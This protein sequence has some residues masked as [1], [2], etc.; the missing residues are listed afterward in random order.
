[1]RAAAAAPATAGCLYPPSSSEATESKP[2]WKTVGSRRSCKT[3]ESASSPPNVS[4]CL[5]VSK[6]QIQK[7]CG[8][9]IPSGRSRQTNRPFH[10]R[11]FSLSGT[12]EGR[13]EGG[14]P[15]VQKR[16]SGCPDEP[17]L[18]TQQ[19]SMSNLTI[20]LGCG[21]KTCQKDNKGCGHVLVRMTELH[22]SLQNVKCGT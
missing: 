14:Q 6:C 2:P 3:P 13:R 11:D 8:A 7:I 20:I 16:V 18:R 21:P 12:F 5:V 9:V 10:G 22:K 4:E 17:A 19:S 15:A 1:M